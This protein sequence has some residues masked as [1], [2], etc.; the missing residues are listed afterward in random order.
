MI[1]QE[2]KDE[3]R[4]YYAAKADLAHLENRLIRWILAQF[5]TAIVTA[6][7]VALA[8]HQFLG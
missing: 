3:M 6:S 8:I 4:E 7:S 5:L 2:V 1:G